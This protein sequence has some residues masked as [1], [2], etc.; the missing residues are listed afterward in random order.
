VRAV[1]G[2][3]AALGRG[4]ERLWFKPYDPLPAAL[5]RICM[6]TL[7]TAMYLA[8]APSFSR[9]F[10]RNGVLSLEDPT[11]SQGPEDWWSLFYLFSGVPLWVFWLLGLVAAIGFTVGWKTRLW[12]IVLFALEMSMSHRNRFA[13]N[14]EDLV[15]RMTLFYGCF[16][17]LGATLSIDE[18]WKRRKAARA[19]AADVPDVAAAPR[20]WPVRL[21]QINVALIYAISL[22]HKLDD[23]VAWRNGDAI[24]LSVTSSLWGRF[25]WPSLF[26][27]TLG[28]VMTYFTVAA[29]GLFPIVVWFARTRPYAVLALASLHLGIAFMLKNVAFFSLG[30]VCCFWLYLPAETIRG[31]WRR[32]QPLLQRLLGRVS[33]FWESKGLDG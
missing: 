1:K 9:Y 33:R 19:A 31:A 21:M 27:G 8:L 26:Y 17:P 25:P 24:F 2:A 6:G 10:G 15:A 20:I 14:G 5:Y 29:E 30:M 16:A 4:W 12:T 13:I 28:D 11:L 32:G 22:P 23:D 18:W 3:L 7:L